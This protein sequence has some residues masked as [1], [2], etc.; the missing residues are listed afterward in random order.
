M[1]NITLYRYNR[2]DGG[3]TVSPVKPEGEYTEMF[4]LVADEGM[5]LTDGNNTTIC[6]DTDNPSVWYEIEDAEF[7]EETTE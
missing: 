5:L 2:P 6:T 1:Q 3:V 4:R 7:V